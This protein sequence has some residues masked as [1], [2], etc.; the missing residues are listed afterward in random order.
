MKT[1]IHLSGQF[2]CCI[3]VNSFFHVKNC[4]HSQIVAT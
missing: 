2:A 4:A 1:G 3:R